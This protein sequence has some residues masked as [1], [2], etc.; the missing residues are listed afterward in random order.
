MKRT[1]EKPETK[2]EKEWAAQKA[3]QTAGRGKE[4]SKRRT[5]RMKQLRKDCM[6]LW[7]RIVVRNWKGKCAVCGRTAAG[8]KL[9]AHH[10]IPRNGHLATMYEPLNGML[11]CYDHHM[12]SDLSPHL[13]PLAFVP[14]LDMMHTWIRPWC[15]QHKG[16]M[17]K[18][19]VA[20]YEATIVKLEAELGKETS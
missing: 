3:G 1:R 5:A 6:D 13:A 7:R 12:G 17:A 20:F 9:N 15:Q 8:T 4:T 10:L 14:W 11:L 2:A 19:T 18:P 16:D